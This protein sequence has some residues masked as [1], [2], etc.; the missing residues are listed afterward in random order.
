MAKK[1]RFSGQLRV[2]LKLND[3]TDQYKAKVCPVRIPGERCETVYVGVPKAETRPSSPRA[4]DGA[5]RAAISFSS[6]SGYANFTRGRITATAIRRGRRV[7]AKGHPK[8]R[9]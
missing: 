2:E 8:R 6:L 3:R 7:Y 4:F 5:A 9:A 1:V